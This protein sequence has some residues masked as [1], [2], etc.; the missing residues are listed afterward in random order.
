[1]DVGMGPVKYSRYL[2]LPNAEEMVHSNV[3]LKARITM[4]VNYQ[5]ESGSGAMKL[6]PLKYRLVSADRRPII[7]GMDE[8]KRL[9]ASTRC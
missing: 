5:K 8:V 7:E 3:P 9:L 2:K 1:M 6:L 4:F